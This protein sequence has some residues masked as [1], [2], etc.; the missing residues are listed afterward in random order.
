MWKNL[1]RALVRFDGGL[2]LLGSEFS[3]YSSGGAV[4]PFPPLASAKW[5]VDNAFESTEGGALRRCSVSQTE[6][7]NPTAKT[8]IVPAV[9]HDSSS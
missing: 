3:L 2:D 5:M 6:T 8:T 4:S 1:A 9:R 7:I